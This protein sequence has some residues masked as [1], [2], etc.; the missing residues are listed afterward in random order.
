MPQI[1]DQMGQSPLITTLLKYKTQFATDWNFVKQFEPVFQSV[2]KICAEYSD[3]GETQI[4]ALKEVFNHFLKT[5]KY[6]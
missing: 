4:K 3:Q 2:L 5:E 1:S 6:F